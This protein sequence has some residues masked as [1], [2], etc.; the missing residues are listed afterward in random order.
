[1]ITLIPDSVKTLLAR[2]Y[3]SHRARIDTE[4][5]SRVYNVI[6]RLCF[7]HHHT[8]TRARV[9]VSSHTNERA[10]ACSR[11]PSRMNHAYTAS[12]RCAHVYHARK[13]F[14]LSRT[15]FTPRDRTRS[16]F[17]TH[18]TLSRSCTCFSCTF[19][20]R[21]GCFGATKRSADPAR[22]DLVS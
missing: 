12:S 9:R 7:P 2:E 15:R 21:L 1:M 19:F 13:T 4:D 20:R 14:G 22:T 3:T 18:V 5:C 8:H 17:L 6:A 10:H 16:R 11:V